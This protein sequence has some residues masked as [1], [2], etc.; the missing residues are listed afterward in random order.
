[1]DI[2]KR[3][4]QDSYSVA[5][6][7]KCSSRVDLAFCLLHPLKAISVWA[8]DGTCR[9]LPTFYPFHPFFMANAKK[10][11]VARATNKPVQAFRMRG[12]SASVFANEV[13]TDDG[14]ELTRYDVSV[15]RRYR[16]G[17]EFK[18]TTSF[19]RD[20]LPIL[21]LLARRAWEFIVDEEAIP[22]KD[23]EESDQ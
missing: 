13:A 20:D 11:T 1:V 4:R 12:I 5:L 6:A 2:H 9:S 17:D 8:S 10:S 19:R 16:D 22:A 7:G 21:Q 3:Q 15:Q 14:R 18:T 23:D